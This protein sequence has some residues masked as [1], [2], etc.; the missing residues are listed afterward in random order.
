MPPRT[1]AYRTQLPVAGRLADRRVADGRA[2][3]LL[4]DDG[5]G[6]IGNVAFSSASKKPSRFRSS[7]HHAHVGRNDDTPW[8]HYARS[9]QGDVHL[10]TGYKIQEVT[11]YKSN[12]VRLGFEN[13][14]T[15][16][17]L[18]GR[19]RSIV[20]NGG[21][22][23]LL[24]GRRKHWCRGVPRLAEAIQRPHDETTGRPPEVGH[25]RNFDFHL[26]SRSA[27]QST[28]RSRTLDVESPA[29]ISRKTLSRNRR[30]QHS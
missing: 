21:I 30:A 2:G 11:G 7:R 26:R 9:G 13:G 5:R 22:V 17:T 4:D 8:S 3:F 27:A 23:P 1:A 6:W 19:M 20:R 12:A 24:V 15:G 10:V 14:K 29:I 16:T 18:P 28:E 25:G